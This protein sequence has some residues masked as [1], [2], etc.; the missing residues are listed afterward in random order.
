MEALDHKVK[1]VHVELGKL[2]A[3]IRDYKKAKVYFERAVENKEDGAFLEYGKWTQYKNRPN[4]EKA[5]ELLTKA[6][7]VGDVKAYSYL[8]RLYHR[9]LNDRSKALEVYS[10]GVNHG[11]ASSAHQLAHVY[12]ELNEYDKADELFFKGK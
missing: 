1:D 11:D 3:R 10:E 6:I 4:N 12:A 7:E 5:K 9:K 2:Y 8:G